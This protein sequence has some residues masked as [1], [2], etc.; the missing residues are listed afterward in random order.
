M[1]SLEQV[2]AQ[3]RFSR[4]DIV[5]LL[6][7]TDPG[8]A[9]CIRK[10]A[11]AILLHECGPAVY[12]RGLIEFSNQCVNDCLYC[13]IRA[14]NRAVR[15]YQLTE[16]E[17]V[18]GARWCAEQGYGSAVLQSGERRDEAFVAFVERVV[19]RIKQAT[20]S[21]ILPSGLGMTLCVGEQDRSAYERFLAAGAHRYLLRI[22][23]TDP[24][25]FA[26]L[27]PPQQTLEARM[28]CLQTLREVGFQVGTGVMIGLPGQ[29][30]EQLAADVEFFRDLDI[31][32]IGMGPYVPHRQTP[33]AEWPDRLL[34]AADRLALALRMISV[35]RIVL[36]NVNI[37]AT[38]AL[39]A[40]AE[41]GREQGLLAGANI[42]MPQLTPTGVRRDYLL[43]EGKPCLDEDAVMC[44]NCLRR[45]IE[46]TGRTLVLDAWGDAPHAVQ[47]QTPRQ[48][49]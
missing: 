47:R 32:M 25:L 8:E 1:T 35:C 22:E 7:T 16:D 33:L 40:L 29:T 42:L 28:A 21:E 24:G 18:D 4:T 5:R 13:G 2:L 3:E 17:I 15:R 19:R 46:T 23:T 41:D 6:S 49:R 12:Y 10:R 45:R 9:D 39:Q 36:R 30:C 11:Q 26:R 27:H 38:T 48:E 37:A 20:V 31:D 34:P 43:Y 14:G 44:R